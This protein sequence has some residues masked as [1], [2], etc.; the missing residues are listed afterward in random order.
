M[1][2]QGCRSGSY[3]LGVLGQV[4]CV[5]GGSSSVILGLWVMAMGSG[6]RVTLAGPYILALMDC[7][8][9][10][11]VLFLAAGCLSRAT[12]LSRGA[13][14]GTPGGSGRSVHLEALLS[15]W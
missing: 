3:L 5:M 2:A 10:Q 8:L 14:S 15:Q 6:H 11:E 7:N 9:G 4:H 1:K 12:W 13:W